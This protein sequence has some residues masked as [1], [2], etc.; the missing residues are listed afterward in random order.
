MWATTP[1]EV[2]RL[3]REQRKRRGLSQQMLAELVGVSRQWVIALEQGKPTAELGLVLQAL[4]AIGLRVDVRDRAD[5]GD[6]ESAALHQATA[7]VIERT[8]A[9]DS[10]PRRLRTLASRRT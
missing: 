8:R 10:P 7:E 4:A 9:G 2:A 6:D 3:V 1:Q 5:A